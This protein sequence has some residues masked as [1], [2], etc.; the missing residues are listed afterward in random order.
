MIEYEP[1]SKQEAAEQIACGVHTGLR[2]GSEAPTSG[3]IWRAI[4]ESDDSAWMDAV[5]YCVY[6]LESMGYAICK[7]VE[8]VEGYLKSILDAT[9]FHPGSKEEA[10]YVAALKVECDDYLD[11]K[12]TP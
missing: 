8:K 10:D 12:E 9:E 4:S 2:K 5:N 7:E 1:V 11:R 3:P 6:G